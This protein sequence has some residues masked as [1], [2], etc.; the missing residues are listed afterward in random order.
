M[1]VESTYESLPPPERS[2]AVVAGLTVA[3]RAVGLIRTVVIATV[4][5]ITYLGNTY[6][7]ANAIPNLLFEIVAGGALAAVLVP[8]LAAPISR[9]NPADLSRTA[10]SFV[11]LTLLVLTPVVVIGLL[12]REPLMMWLTSG[13]PDQAVRMAQVELGKFFL[14]VFLP[15][16]WLY[17]L[18]VVLT[19]IL[20]AHHRFAGPAFAPLLSSVVVTVAVLVYGFTE[21]S[22]AASLEEVSRRGILILGFGTTAGVAVLALS[23]LVPIRKLSISWRPYLKIPKESGQIAKRLLGAALVAVAGQQVLLAVVLVIA[24][25]IE[26]GVVAYQL[27]FTV[28]LLPWAVLA[29]PLAV[30]SF[31]GMAT[32]IADGKIDEFRKRCADASGMVL[33]V[34]F[35][36]AALLAGTA[37]PL[38]R[39]VLTFGAANGSSETLVTNTILAFAPGMIGY[40]AY[41]YL[42]RVAYAQGDGRSPATAAAV[43]FGIGIVGSVSAPIFAKGAFLVAALAGSFSIGMIVGSLLLLA[44]LRSTAGS[45]AFSGLGTASIRGTVAAVLAA[46]A[47]FLA[48]GLISGRSLGLDLGAALLASFAVVVVY[49]GVQAI[50]GD[51]D[52]PRTYSAIRGAR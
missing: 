43:G 31:P 41:A 13:V 40:G 37:G 33:Y 10:S 27:A 29:V 14:L 36:G 32:A 28:L 47:G 4:L 3:S 50:L 24:N 49:I 45:E 2:A 48:S 1:T 7:S 20:H 34:C 9:K 42:S 5:G 8:A 22:A 26:G 11:N 19:G 23:L 52:L 30:A 39:A 15:Q 35:G 17:G 38:A 6:A 16:I 12:L 51:R 44:R 25:R 21:G 46:P 18:G